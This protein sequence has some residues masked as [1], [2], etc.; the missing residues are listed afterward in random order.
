MRSDELCLL[1]HAKHQVCAVVGYVDPGRDKASLGSAVLRGPCWQGP[2]NVLLIR[3]PAT[4]SM[5]Y[6]PFF[7]Q[8]NRTGPDTTGSRRQYAEH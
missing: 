6:A 1:G 5:I 3:S 4:Y 7:Q 8:A 2:G